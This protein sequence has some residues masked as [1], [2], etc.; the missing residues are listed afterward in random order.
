M[1]P[2]Q[3][4]SL[5]LSDKIDTPNQTELFRSRFSMKQFTRLRS[6]KLIEIDDPEDSL[7]FDLYQHQHLVSLEIDV[8]IR[9]P[10]MVPIPSLKRLIINIPLDIHSNFDPAFTYVGYEQLRQLTL[11]NC[12]C[13]QLQKIFCR[14][15]QLQSLK[16]SLRFLDPNEIMIPPNFH[17]EQSL[18]SSL[19]S[20]SL[21]IESYG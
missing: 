16:I 6:L 11:S 1:K 18:P 5:I 21:S 19:I 4:I 20:L 15:I 2:E 13:E 12:S 7:I 8:K 14:A 9:A 17:Q 3:V 10:F